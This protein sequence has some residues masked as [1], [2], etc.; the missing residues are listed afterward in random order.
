MTSGAYTMSVNLAVSKVGIEISSM[1][2]RNYTA[3][4][5]WVY[6]HLVLHIGNSQA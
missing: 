5:F 6:Q 4:G 3:S 1:K 2:E